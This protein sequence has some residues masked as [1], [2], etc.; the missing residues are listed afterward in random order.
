MYLFIHKILIDDY[1]RDKLQN[2]KRYTD[3]NIAK[4]ISKT[5]I[6]LAVTKIYYDG[7]KTDLCE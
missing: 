4:E 7:Q 3:Q 6:V 5:E 1:T 2:S